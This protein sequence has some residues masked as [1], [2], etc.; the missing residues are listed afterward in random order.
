VGELLLIGDIAIDV[1]HLP[2]RSIC[3]AGGAALYTALAARRCGVPVAMFGLRPDPLPGILA[4]FAG[5]LDSYMGPRVTGN[6]LPLFEITPGPANA[7]FARVRA[8]AA[9][10]LTPDWLPGDLSQYGLVHVTQAAGPRWQLDMV[11]A[12]RRRGARVISAGTFPCSSKEAAEAVRSV[13]AEVD[14]FFLN[15]AEAAAVYG[16]L[17]SAQALPERLLYVTLGAD[18]VLV[19]EGEKRSQLTAVQAVVLDPTGAGDSFCGAALAYLLQDYSPVAAAQWGVKVAA[20]MIAQI[21]PS[22]LLD[23]LHSSAS[24]V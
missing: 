24:Q 14:I 8:G 21:G 20:E 3:S 10:L 1:L 4:A 22:A 11:R 9:H 5:R 18:G 2:D 15:G 12:C 19:C 13:I 16:S 7:G 6:D 23:D 17:A